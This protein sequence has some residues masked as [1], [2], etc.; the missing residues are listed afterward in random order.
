MK[1]I[2]LLAKVFIPISSFIAMFNAVIYKMCSNSISIFFSND[3]WIYFASNPMWHEYTVSLNAVFPTSKNIHIHHHMWK[4]IQYGAFPLT[5]FSNFTTGITF[6]ALS[7]MAAGEIGWRFIFSWKPQ[8]ME[9]YPFR[10]PHSKWRFN[11]KVL[12]KD[13]DIKKGNVARETE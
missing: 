12:F 3:S 5:S 6:S 2:S 13:H 9:F 7:H 4:H 1:S 11:S 10:A 8:E